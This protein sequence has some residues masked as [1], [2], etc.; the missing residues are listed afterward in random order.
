VRDTLI[1]VE[2][3]PEQPRVDRRALLRKAAAAGALGWTAPVILS[4]APAAAGV[5]TAKCAPG[6]ITIRDTQFEQ[7]GCTGADTTLTIDIRFRFPPACPCGGPQQRCAQVNSPG[8][9]STLFGGGRLRF[10][11]VV[12]IGATITISGKVAVGCTD[13]DGDTQFSVYDWTMTATD[14]GAACDVASSITGAV[15]TGPPTLVTSPTCP[16]L[17]AFATSVVTRSATA[18]PPGYVRPT[19]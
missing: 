18:L 5:F 3:V 8:V 6:P 19:S 10:T 1:T 15:L 4:S 11:V 2:D 13:R 14:N 12:P 16:S 17:T 7:I 9:P